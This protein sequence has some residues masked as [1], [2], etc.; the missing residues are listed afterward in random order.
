MRVLHR[1]LREDDAIPQAVGQLTNRCCLMGT[2]ETEPAELLPPCLSQRSASRLKR[3]DREA[4]ESREWRGPS[5]EVEAARLR[6]L[7]ILREAVD[8]S[9]LP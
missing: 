2:R 8:E 3:N 9:D 4:S 7:A 6:L 1:Q 5:V